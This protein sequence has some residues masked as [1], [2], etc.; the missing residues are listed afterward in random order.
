MRSE[1]EYTASGESESDA[2]GAEE[3][4]WANRSN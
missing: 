3:V 2:P 4:P 1:F